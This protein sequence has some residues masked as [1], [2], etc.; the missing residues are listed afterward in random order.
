MSNRKSRWIEMDI[1]DLKGREESIRLEFKAGALFD[2]PQATWVANLSK[3]VSAFA[4]TEGG[5][6]FLG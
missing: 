5:F 1:A 2:K 3:E 6:S 4:N